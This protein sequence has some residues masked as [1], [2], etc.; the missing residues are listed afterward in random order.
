VR[1]SEEGSQ[2]PIGGG[3]REVQ[4]TSVVRAAKLHMSHYKRQMGS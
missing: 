2:C 4:R 3:D 1:G